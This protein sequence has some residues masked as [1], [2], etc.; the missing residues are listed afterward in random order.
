MPP[1]RLPASRLVAGSSRQVRLLSTTAQ[2]LPAHMAFRP[3]RPTP[4]LAGRSSIAHIH[5]APCL[6][7]VRWIR[8]TKSSLPLHPARRS[9]APSHQRLARPSAS[10][11]H[12]QDEPALLRV[13]PGTSVCVR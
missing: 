13:H 6:V 12:E 7:S 10:P 9:S 2:P 4:D 1:R 3:H 11:V 8:T 5:G